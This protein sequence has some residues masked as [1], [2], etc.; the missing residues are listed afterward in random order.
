MFQIK[1]D[2]HNIHD[3]HPL[4]ILKAIIDSNIRWAMW[5]IDF[6]GGGDFHMGGT[7]FGW[8]R[9]WTPEDTV[10][11]LTIKSRNDYISI[12]LKYLS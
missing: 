8:G 11:T 7:H 5:E 6:L 3:G 2:L 12:F 4:L 10:Y 9:V 1:I